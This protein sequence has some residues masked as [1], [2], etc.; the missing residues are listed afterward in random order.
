MRPQEGVAL[1]RR[2]IIQTFILA[3]CVSKTLASEYLLKAKIEVASS[4][5]S[6]VEVWIPLP[7]NDETQKVKRLVIES[8]GPFL[9]STEKEYGNR[10]LY[11]RFRNGKKIIR[12]QALI[13]RKEFAPSP[14]AKPPSRWLL[15]DRLVPL[16]PF[17]ELALALTSAE[18]TPK[19]KL[20][21][22]YDYVVTHLRYDK[23]G[24]GWGR[25]D[26]LF[27]CQN[28]RGNC[29]DFHSLFMALAR[30]S[31]FPTLFEIGLPVQQDGKVKG[32]HCWLMVYVNGKLW[33]IDASEAAKHPEK[34]AYFFGRLCNKRILL[35]R[36]RDILLSPP[37]HG[38]RLNFIWK[39]YAEA[40]L[41]PAPHL[42]KTTYQIDI[43]QK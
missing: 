6:L 21:A 8:P 18:K 28:K 12:Y 15:P 2:L 3:L 1:M 16:D 26:A 30:V 29:T 10:I 22:I 42:V 43:I 31:G 37:Q 4:N 34:R 17:K 7:L 19:A 32:Y 14:S 41:K 24:K 39:A 36:G 11:F 35:S 25:G 33:G 27:A 20:F 13:E 38:P 5:S 23:S 9:V 40:D